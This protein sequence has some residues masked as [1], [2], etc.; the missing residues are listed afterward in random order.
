MTPWSAQAEL[1]LL[2]YE[3]IVPKPARTELVNAGCG[4]VG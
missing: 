2:M 3:Q 4:P 1:E